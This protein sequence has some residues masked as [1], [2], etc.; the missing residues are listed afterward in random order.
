M[1]GERKQNPAAPGFE[2]AELISQEE[3]CRFDHFTQGDALRLGEIM[4]SISREV[5]MPF[6][7]EIFLNGMVVF[8]YMPEGT[9][10]L[11]DA[12]MEKK[13]ETVLTTGWSTMR[14]WAT[15]EAIGVHREGGM[16]PNNKYV[17]CG[18]GFPIF[19][20]GVGVVGAIA[21]SGPGD[22]AEHEFLV[23]S[24]RRFR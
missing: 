14:V 12:W 16:L 5:S 17:M 10:R 3:E 6:G 15:H 22:Q 9:G 18:G 23:E 2:L 20:N 19:V 24:I 1:I 7:V 21:C 11:N 4:V 8:K 13:I